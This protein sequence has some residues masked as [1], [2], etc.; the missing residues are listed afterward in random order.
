MINECVHEQKPFGVV[1]IK[2]GTEV[3]EL[4]EP[5]DIGTTARIASVQRMSEGRLNLETL[6]QDRFRIIELIHD[7][8]I[9]PP[10]SKTIQ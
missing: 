10:S 3:G 7:N 9:S 4:A 6:G 2:S 5:H 8:R 1:L